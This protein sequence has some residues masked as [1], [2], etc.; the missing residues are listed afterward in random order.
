MKNLIDFILK[1]IHWLLFI[2]LSATSFY[3]LV[4]NNEFQRSKYLSVFQEIAGRV[5]SVSNEVQS[6]LN[7]K[8]INADLMKRIAVLEEDKQI[9]RKQLDYLYDQMQPDSIKLGIND[10]IYHYTRARVRHNEMYGPEKYILL[11]KGSKDEITED[12]AVVS[13]KGIVGVVTKVTPRTSR[14]MPI[15]NTGYHPNCMIKNTRFL[16]LLFWDGKDPRY[17]HLSQLQ[18]HA[19]YSVG[20]TVVT[21]GN[22]A[23]FPEGVDVGVIV[24]SSTDKNEENNSVKVRLFTDFSTLNEVHIIKNP[25]Y[26]EL[27]QIEK[28]EIEE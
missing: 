21:S 15:L 8:T 2:F 19:S 20:D 27:K 24:E 16:G 18:S 22:S 4:N 1:N 26:E 17:I 25:L 9:Y 5:Y 12:M 7:L 3:F 6:Y 11:D 28:G 10:N 13:V 14:V 23:V